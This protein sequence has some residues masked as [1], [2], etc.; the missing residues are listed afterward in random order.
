MRAAAGLSLAI[1]AFGVMARGA[2][3]RDYPMQEAGHGHAP[4]AIGEP[5]QGF[6]LY[7]AAL[8]PVV[9]G[10]KEI[11]VTAMDATLPISKDVNFAGWTYDG[12]IPGKMLRVVEGDM[13]DFT[14]KVDPNALIGHSLDFHSARVSPDDKYRTI[15]QGEEFSYTFEAQYP[16][17]Y[18]YHCGTPP[19]L[20]HLGAGMFGAMIVDPK[21][22]WS[23]AQEFA[24][25]QSEYYLT[26]DGSGTGTMTS[27]YAAMVGNG[28]P[29]LTV[30]N[31]YAN[32]YAENPIPCKVGEPMR[33]FVMNA[34]PNAW[35]SFHVVGTIFDRAYVNGNPKNELVGL[36]SITIGPGDGAVVEFSL[37]E[38][39]HYPFVN[40]SFGHA[41]QGAV[42]LFHAQ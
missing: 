24:F 30:F 18:M 6:K 42:G 8:A 7:D 16:G 32:Q 19:I 31:G 38:P 5:P 17:V 28:T 13:I 39:G 37:A 21:E 33:V 1:P 25:V 10:P 36:Q 27:N 40:H 20:M 22:G 29:S 15:S 11:T 2:G 14:F 26:D 12:S 34:G 35:T 23:P 9:A 41:S 3:A 4:A